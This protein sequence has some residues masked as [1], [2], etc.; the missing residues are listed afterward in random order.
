MVND[1]TKDVENFQ[2]EITISHQYAFKP[3]IYTS[4]DLLSA[5]NNLIRI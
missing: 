5:P 2:L 1:K 4:L 3:I